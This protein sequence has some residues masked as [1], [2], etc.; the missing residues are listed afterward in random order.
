MSL[1]SHIEWTDATWNPV[2][3]ARRSARLQALLRRDVCGAVPRVKGIPTSRG[4]IWVGAGEAG[5]AVL[6]ADAEAH[7]CEFDERSVPGRVPDDYIE[8]S[9]GLWSTADWH[10]FQVLTKRAERLRDC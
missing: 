7:V 8:A 6:M 9:A 3:A 2:A 1:N 4:S 5:R 10:T